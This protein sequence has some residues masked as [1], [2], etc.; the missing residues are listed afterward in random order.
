MAKVHS[1]DIFYINEESIIAVKFLSHL[2]N[3][4]LRV[5]NNDTYDEMPL[6]FNRLQPTIFTKNEVYSISF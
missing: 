2:S 6:I 1:S 3:T 5:I 4:I